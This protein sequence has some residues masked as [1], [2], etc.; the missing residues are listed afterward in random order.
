[1]TR[2]FPSEKWSKQKKRWQQTSYNTLEKI[3]L[4]NSKKKKHSRPAPPRARPMQHKFKFHSIE[5]R[6]KRKKRT[7]KRE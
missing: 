2:V 6:R 5:T 1:M 4:N 3:R 7:K